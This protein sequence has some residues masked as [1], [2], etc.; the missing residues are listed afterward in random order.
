MVGLT[1]AGQFLVLNDDS[2][3]Q[4]WKLC[5]PQPERLFQEEGKIWALSSDSRIL[6]IAQKDSAII[7]DLASAK[8]ICRVG[9]GSVVTCLAIHPSNHQIAIGDARGVVVHEISTGKYASSWKLPDVDQIAW[10]PGGKVLAGVGSDRLVQLWNPEMHQELCRLKGITNAGIR[11]AFDHSGELIATTGW[12]GLLRLWDSRTGQQVLQTRFFSG[13]TPRFHCSLRLVAG[14]AIGTK[15]R[16][17]EITPPRVRRTF[18]RGMGSP[19]KGFGYC[20]VSADGR[21]VAVAQGGLDIWDLHTGKQLAAVSSGDFDNVL[22]ERGGLLVQG[23]SG[24]FRWPLGDKP[25]LAGVITLGP[26]ERLPI[27]GINGTQIAK[28]QDGE[29]FASARYWGALVWRRERP[30]ELL[31]LKPHDDARFVAVSPD[32]HWVVT[33]SHN[34][35]GAKI[36]DAHTRKLK[37]V[38]LPLQGWVHVEFSP[39]N[40]WLGTSASGYGIRLWKVPTWEEGLFLGAGVFPA[41][42]AF[43]PDGKWLA[44][45]TGS[46]SIHLVDIESG[47]EI[48]TLEDPDQH[49]AYSI[50]IS[51]DSGKLVAISGENKSGF[52]VW[53]LRMIQ[54]ELKRMGLDSDLLPEFRPPT[55]TSE[56]RPITMEVVRGD[57]NTNALSRVEQA[58]ADLVRHRRVFAAHPESAKACNRLARIHVMAPSEIRDTAEMLMAARKAVQI[59]PGN[60]SNL[61]T[62]GAAYFR[63]GQFQEAIGTLEKAAQQASESNLPFDLYFLAMSWQSLKDSAKARLYYDWAERWTH[64]ELNLEPGQ[65][66]ELQQLRTEAASMLGIEGSAEKD[67]PTPR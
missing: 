17:W 34:F 55:E 52:Q 39:D 1:T 43:S 6:A 63:A 37:K 66:M 67:R 7:F 42:F 18:G 47:K 25:S 50:S 33:G 5:H 40:R 19:T 58:R 3:L 24:L 22:F 27:P 9:K 54:G 11:I 23:A 13:G 31:S 15:L 38:L 2:H 16:T 60:W 28:D 61:N 64:P 14:D 53:D 46:G 12:E 48:L 8:E 57:A 30:Q 26:P 21:L 20:S 32:N 36:W 4:L 62:L 29:L 59:E 56:T 51:P 41:P 65:R 35:T 45:E 44:H 10:H 49:I